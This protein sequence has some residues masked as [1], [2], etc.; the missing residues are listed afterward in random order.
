M[1][2]VI[3]ISNIK[4]GVGKTTLCALFCEFLKENGFEVVAI[5]LSSD[6]YRELKK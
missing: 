2:K 6:N 5:S 4:G 1:N 3:L